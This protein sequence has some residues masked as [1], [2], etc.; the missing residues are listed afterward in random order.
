M[1]TSQVQPLKGKPGRPRKGAKTSLPDWRG[2]LNPT[3]RV[4]LDALE[5]NKQVLTERRKGLIVQIDELRHRASS[6]RRNQ[7]AQIGAEHVDG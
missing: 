5:K 6:R 3:E 2:F 1:P 7:L 4:E